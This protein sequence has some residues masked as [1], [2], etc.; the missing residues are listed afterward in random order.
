MID[1]LNLAMR[2]ESGAILVP[3]PDFAD[4]DVREQ[5]VCFVSHAEYERR[6]VEWA[7]A[8]IAR[9]TALMDYEGFDTAWN[10]RHAPSPPYGYDGA[11]QRFLDRIVDAGWTPDSSC[12]GG[13]KPRLGEGNEEFFGHAFVVHGP[14][15]FR[16]V[17]STPHLM[18][19]TGPGHGGGGVQ[20][21]AF[22]MANLPQAV[23]NAAALA[24]DRFGVSTFASGT[25][26]SYIFADEIA[27]GIVLEAPAPCTDVE[28]RAWWERI[29]QL[30]V[31]GP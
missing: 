22:E 10:R 12:Q 15:G 30:A 17:K 9:T 16:W 8:G 11:I 19:R 3:H 23:Y 25:A 27:S 4:G 1:E 31:E 24:A 26:K 29:T 2:A 13:F 21:G 18:L 14:R 20:R 28:A 7:C 5:R 6:F